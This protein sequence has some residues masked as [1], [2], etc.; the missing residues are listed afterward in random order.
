MSSDTG[1]VDSENNDMS[2]ETDY[3]TQIRDSFLLDISEEDVQRFRDFNR[4]SKLA[5]T[6][7]AIICA[8]SLI[9]VPIEGFFGWVFFFPGFPVI[10]SM[11]S[12]A[13]LIFVTYV[14]LKPWE[15]K[16][17][18]TGV[19]YQKIARLHM[20]KAIKHYNNNRYDLMDDPLKDL[21]STLHSNSNYLLGY[22]EEISNYI[23]IV[24]GS[25][26]TEKCLQETFPWIA[27]S[28]LV[29]SKA[30]EK[31]KNDI[32]AAIQK[33]N[34]YGSSSESTAPNFREFHRDLAFDYITPH[35][36]DL[37][38]IITM[39]VIVFG[40]HQLI[41]QSLGLILGTLL[42]FAVLAYFASKSFRK[43]NEGN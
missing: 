40:I 10:M 37:I 30:Q 17:D 34:R 13:V 36:R 28:L 3:Q 12:F 23:S 15:K 19:T 16:R 39:C 11:V 32:E 20:N 18:D 21:D 38:V 7:F 41:D 6:P 2:D 31:T 29:E 25:E 42:S 43:E 24:L 14:L 26:N 27:N 35:R 1:G 8:I 33:I 5:Q 22:D 4:K 9:L